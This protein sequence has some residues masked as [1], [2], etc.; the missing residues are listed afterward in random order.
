MPTYK[1]ELF[2][3]AKDDILELDNRA[4]VLVF[5]QLKKIERSPELGELLG[6]KAGYELSR[7][8]KMYADNK[9]I[10]IVYR[11]IEDKIIIEVIAIGERDDMAVYKTA[12]D[13]L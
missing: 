2:P 1:I 3:E 13:R 10:R 9:R 7:C 4:R 11:I 6:S 8:R 5:K 12:S